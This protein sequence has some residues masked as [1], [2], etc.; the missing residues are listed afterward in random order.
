[1]QTLFLL[2]H[3]VETSLFVLAVSSK[4]FKIEYAGSSTGT[5]Y[6][7]GAYLGESITKAGL[8]PRA[9]RCLAQRAVRRMS[10]PRMSRMAIMQ[11]V[12]RY[13][14]SPKGRTLCQLHVLDALRMGCLPYW[15]AG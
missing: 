3:T 1:M 10:T 8:P 13:D 12:Q 9:V 7:R 14:C 15:S 2:R 5:L 11:L 4:D 6:G